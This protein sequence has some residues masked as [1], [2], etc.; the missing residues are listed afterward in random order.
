[1]VY[2]NN[3]GDKEHRISP[4]TV[5]PFLWGCFLLLAVSHPFCARV[6]DVDSSLTH[7]W[8]WLQ[9]SGGSWQSSQQHQ[10][11]TRPHPSQPLQHSPELAEPCG[12][13][14]EDSQLPSGNGCQQTSLVF[15]FVIQNIVRS[16]R[17][18]LC[19][20]ETHPKC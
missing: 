1:M 17:S 9:L 4:S 16:F 6:N 3:S 2:K 18:C 19:S 14:T 10:Q 13:T 20:V 5:F 8:L 11:E 7:P 12:A 15:E